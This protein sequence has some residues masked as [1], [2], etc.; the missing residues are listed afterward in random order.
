MKYYTGL[1][2]SLK[3]TSIC[4]LNQDGKV[5]FEETS[6]TDP[7]DIFNTLK[8]TRI[9]IEK[10]ALESGSIS[11]WLLKELK[12]R[13]LSVICID[14]RKMSKVLSININKTDKNDA[15]MI[16]E[17]LRCKFYSEVQQKSQEHV[18]LGILLSS[19]R[20]LINSRTQLKNTIR[21]HLK[22]FGIRLGTLGST[23][24]IDAVTKC[25][26]DKASAVKIAISQLLRA[27]EQLVHQICALDTE[28]EKMALED[29][30]VHLLKTIPGV[31]TITAYTFKA[32]LGD[33][34]RFKNSR[35]VGAYF[36]LTPRQ[37]SSGETIQQG[38]ISKC[39]NTEV[40]HM[41]CEAALVALY[42]AKSWSKIKSWG[43]KII[44][45]RGHKKAKIAVARKYSVIMHRMLITRKPF[46]FGEQIDKKAEL[47]KQIKREAKEKKIEAD[48]AAIGH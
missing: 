8:G 31:G 6:A 17:A 24:F 20:T 44:K 45:K 37:Y 27:F 47:A 34:N 21:G 23:K 26:K 19:R 46:E 41:L 30:D 48:L 7:S 25:L 18:D 10:I 32:Y 35:A 12:G 15:R 29:A 4:I 22:A 16:A 13:G 36:G 2:V 28:I 39:G 1:D 3:T 38:S 11:N 40:R 33:P 42:R 9:D 14:S 5:I 43:H